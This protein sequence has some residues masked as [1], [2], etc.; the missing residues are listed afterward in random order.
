MSEVNTLTRN[1]I[2]SY[3]RVLASTG[4][5][6]SDNIGDVT[7]VVATSSGAAVEALKHV[8]EL[9]ESLRSELRQT[10]A[11]ARSLDSI[12]KS[13]GMFV[14]RGRAQLLLYGSALLAVASITYGYHEASRQ[15]A[16]DPLGAAQTFRP[17]GD[18]LFQWFTFAPLVLTLVFGWVAAQYRKAST[19]AAPAKQ[20]LS[21]HL[22]ANEGAFFA[23]LR[24]QPPLRTELSEQSEGRVIVILIACI[25][26]GV[27]FGSIAHT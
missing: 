16:A 25:V 14:D 26:I 21:K 12:H 22:D 18:F 8:D 11:R 20:L 19:S 5:L 3:Q 6:N 17:I 15:I 13:V 23:F 24:K 10:A 4:Q 7:R 9:D 2:E 1:L 27:I